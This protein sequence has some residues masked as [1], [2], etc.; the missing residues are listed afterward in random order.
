MLIS[1]LPFSKSGSNQTLEKPI[2][3]ASLLFQSGLAAVGQLFNI[4]SSTGPFLG[5]TGLFA[6]LGIDTLLARNRRASYAEHRSKENGGDGTNK[7]AKKRIPNSTVQSDVSLWTYAIAMLI[8]LTTGI[9]LLATSLVV[10]VP[11]VWF[12]TLY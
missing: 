11:L 6:A 4:G 1:Q 5:A 12:A 10:F 8:P 9:Q 7:A 3:V 2:L